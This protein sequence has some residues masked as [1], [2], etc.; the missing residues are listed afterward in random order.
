MYDIR[1]ERVY[2]EKTAADGARVLMDRLW[3]R[4]K[5][6]EDLNLTEWYPHASPSPQLRRQWH[7][8]KINEA[9]FSQMYR[10]ELAQDPDCL[11]PLMRYARQGRL[12]LLTASRDP[13]HS[14]LPDLRSAVLEGLK[15]EDDADR[16]PPSS[17]ICYATDNCDA[18]DNDRVK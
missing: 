3:P 14:H 18:P 17:P 1:L 6:R 8:N 7:Q 12:T 5:T 15:K 16:S 4:G 2:S 11:T 9:T 13:Q 10:A